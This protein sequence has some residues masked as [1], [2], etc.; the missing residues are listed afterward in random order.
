MLQGGVAHDLHRSVR[1]GHD[2]AGQSQ[3]GDFFYDWKL[4]FHVSAGQGD[5]RLFPGEEMEDPHSGHELGDDGGQRGSLDAHAEHKDKQGIQNQVQ[6]SSNGHREHTCDAEALGVDKV[7]HAKAHHHKERAAQVNSEVGVRIGIGY[8]AGAEKIHQRAAEN[9][10]Q[11]GKDRTA[12]KEHG[13]GICHDLFCL[14]CL[15]SSPG[16]GEER[17]AAGA[18]QVGK[19]SDDSDDGKSEAD[20]GQ[21]LGGGVGNVTDVDPVHHII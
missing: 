13:K 21:G 20:P 8:I 7:V 5:D 16:N 10:A 17:G 3:S 4:R 18:E 9:V 6:H 1:D 14:F 19:G 15:A 2:K 12:Y 11:D